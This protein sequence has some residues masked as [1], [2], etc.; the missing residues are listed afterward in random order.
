M[1]DLKGKNAQELY[2]RACAVEGKTIDRCVLY[3]FR[4]AVYFAENNVHDA[5]KLK[6]WNWKD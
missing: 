3:I 4:L 2:D 1:S 5:E 6:C